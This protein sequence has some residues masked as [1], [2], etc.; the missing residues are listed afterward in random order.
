MKEVIKYIAFPLP[1][2]RRF[3]TEPNRAAADIIDYGIF[4]A[5]MGIR[6]SAP[7]APYRQ[8]T[9]EFI[10]QGLQMPHGESYRVPHGIS[11]KLIK[12]MKEKEVLWLNMIILLMMSIWDILE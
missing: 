10:K 7:E 12:L 6:I 1:M 5:A 2:I 11:H 8:L 3:F 4:R 9:Y